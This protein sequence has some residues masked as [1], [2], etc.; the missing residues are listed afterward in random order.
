MN[1]FGVKVPWWV[2]GLVA[3]II[4]V[5]LVVS[6][7][8]AVANFVVLVFKVLLAVAVLGGVLWVLSKLKNRS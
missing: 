2:I 4:L 6:I 7:V 1:I 8:T 5:V 3:L